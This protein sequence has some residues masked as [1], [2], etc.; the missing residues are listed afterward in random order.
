MLERAKGLCGHSITIA[1]AYAKLGV[2]ASIAGL[3][4]LAGF[5]GDTDVKAS[6]QAV[7]PSEKV[8]IA[9]MG[10]AVITYLARTRGS[11]TPPVAATGS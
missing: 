10:I 8:G 11:L 9:L 3:P 7:L 1:W 5:L 6:I 2:G 4:T